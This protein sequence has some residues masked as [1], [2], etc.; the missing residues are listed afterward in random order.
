[1]YIFSFLSFLTCFM[2]FIE[3]AGCVCSDNVS[4]QSWS[5]VSSRKFKCKEWDWEFTKLHNLYHNVPRGRNNSTLADFH[6]HFLHLK[7]EKELACSDIF[8]NILFLSLKNSVVIQRNAN[9]TEAEAQKNWHQSFIFGREKQ[10][11]K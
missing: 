4:W 5:L 1:M 6:L 9:E 8:E 11:I 7:Q 3:T 2:W 10:I